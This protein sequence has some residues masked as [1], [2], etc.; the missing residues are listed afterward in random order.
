MKKI[1][2]LL[3]MLLLLLAACGSQA[4]APTSLT[5]TPRLGQSST[6]PTSAPIGPLGAAGCKPASPVHTSGVAGPE[7]EGTSA[8]A[9]LWI[10]LFNDLITG[11]D[12]KMV[13]RMTGSGSLHVAAIGPQ[14]QQLD[15]DWGPEEHGGSNWDRPG[16]EWG[17]GFTFAVAGCWDMHATRDDAS[18]DVWLVIA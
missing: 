1:S 16:D 17:T 18:G 8:N 13:W 9:S 2:V 15:P 3:G 7:I 5:A 6:T 14:G 10:L 12:I 11:Q 4:Q